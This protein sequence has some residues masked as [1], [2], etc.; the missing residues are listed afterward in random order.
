M[1]RSQRSSARFHDHPESWVCNSI[2][3]LV[4]LVVTGIR[5]FENV[6]SQD[7]IAQKRSSAGERCGCDFS[8]ML[9]C[10][11]VPDTDDF[12]AV[13]AENYDMYSVF[14]L[15]YQKTWYL[16]CFSLGLTKNTGIYAVCSMLQDVVSMSGKRTN[17][18]FYDVFAS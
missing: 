10:G 11:G 12:G 2:N 17:T 16:Q 14:C 15:R 8:H 7:S 13:E 18:V 4:Q 5:L 3:W 6:L 1:K 9:M